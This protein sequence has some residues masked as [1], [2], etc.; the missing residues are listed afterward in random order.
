MIRAHGNQALAAQFAE[1]SRHADRCDG[2]QVCK[3]R[4]TRTET[5]IVPG[6]SVK[7]KQRTRKPRTRRTMRELGNDPV[8]AVCG[9]LPVCQHALAGTRIGLAYLLEPGHR[10]AA[11]RPGLHHESGMPMELPHKGRQAH[12]TR[13]TDQPNDALPAIGARDGLLHQTAL[14]HVDRR[15]GP[16]TLEQSDPFAQR[17][18]GA[19][20]QA[21]ALKASFFTGRWTHG[22]ERMRMSRFTRCDVH[23]V[24]GEACHASSRVRHCQ[25]NDRTQTSR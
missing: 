2:Q 3:V 23:S 10:D 1:Q 19:F 25:T 24:P 20:A 9:Q 4:S 12:H 16:S 18:A 8:A 21:V 6:Y 22:A 11:R 17:N 5:R 15:G 14:N 7:M 13:S